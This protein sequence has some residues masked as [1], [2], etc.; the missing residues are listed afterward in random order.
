MISGTLVLASTSRTRASL[1]QAAGFSTI[2]DPPG[3]DEDEVKAAFRAEGADAGTCATALAEA[4]AER[5]SRRRPGKL[6]IGADQ[7]LECN[8]LWFDKPPDR[9]HARAQ[10]VALRART[11]ML[12]T[13]ACAFHDGANL[14]HTV[15]RARLTMRPFS[16]AFL[17]AYL[18]S[19]GDDVT[20][21]VG[22]YRLEGLGAHLFSR[23]E[24]DWF[25]ILGLPLL[26]LLDFLRGRGA[27]AS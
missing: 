23:I 20:G 6:V 19:V 7:M 10:L 13:A 8:G 18:A 25:T 21:S 4:K 12:I 22:A 24:G 9:D 3:V 26:P 1:L 14:W 17:E 5:V 16:D 2:A 27:A 15:E 11:H